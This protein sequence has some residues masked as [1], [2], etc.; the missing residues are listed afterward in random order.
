MT[1]EKPEIPICS[2]LGTRRRRSRVVVA[3]VYIP[4]EVPP[5]SIQ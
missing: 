1:I 2:R 3:L 4:G 5:Q